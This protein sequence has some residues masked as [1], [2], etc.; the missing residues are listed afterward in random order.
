[1]GYPLKSNDVNA[2]AKESP[3][4][5]AVASERLLIHRRLQK[6]LVVVEVMCEWWR[7]PVALSLLVV[8]SSVNK[9]SIHPFNSPYPVDSHTRK[10]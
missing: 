4:L 1:V 2:E 10:L 6:G 5:E 9:R 3:L 7:L 8:Q